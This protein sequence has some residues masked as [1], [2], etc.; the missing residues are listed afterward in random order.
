MIWPDDFINKV[1]CGDCLEVM[2][3]IPD[4]AVDLVLTDPPYGKGKNFK[5]D[6][7]SD[8]E[9]YEYLL[10]IF[11]EIERTAKHHILIDTPKDKLPLF[12]DLFKSSKYEYSIVLYES[13]NM[14]NGK[15]GYSVYSL[16]LWFTQKHK[17]I[18]R[19]RDVICSPI[20]NTIKHFRHPSPKN[21]NFYSRLIRMFSNEDDLILDPFLGSGTTV[22]ACKRLKRRFVGIEIDPDYCSI[23]EDR[24]SQGVL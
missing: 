1:I 17:P 19:Y 22:E 2:K 7:F 14:R 3:D 6:D 4:K 12:I 9:L 23:A 8:S 20:E 21:I 18:N 16:I 11:H 15:V 5:G 13:N 10:P 24:L